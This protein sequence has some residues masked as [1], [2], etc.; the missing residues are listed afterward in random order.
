MKNTVYRLI[1]PRNIEAQDEQITIKDGEVLVRPKYLA[2]CAADQRYYLGKR[3]KAD[4]EKKLPLALI[5][6]SWGEIESSSNSGFSKGDKVFMIPNIPTEQDAEIEENYLRS[7]KFHG[8]S[9]DGFMQQHVVMNSDRVVKF[10]NIDKTVA[11]IAEMISVAIHA[12]STF[13]ESVEQK[14]GTIG[15]WGDGN[16]GFL[17]C[18]MLK[19]L[20]PTFKVTVFGIDQ[21]KL[22]QFTFVDE[23]INANNIPEEYTVDFAFECVG[24]KV[25][26]EVIDQIIETI[27]PE[28]TITLMGVSEKSVLINTRMI[29][30]KGLNII[31]RSRSGRAAFVL[32]AEILDGN[33][34]IQEEIKKIIKKTLTIHNVNDMIN[35]FEYDAV[36]SN[37]TVMK[38]EI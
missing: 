23:V 15:V 28:G 6:E 22:D 30:E 12:I 38:W 34:G 35:A 29:L 33:T 17:T 20:L 37:K 7:S 21:Q 32:V 19:E 10:V 11:A 1:K 5:H 4:L 18:L 16:L 3:N 36:S 9:L 31:G 2:I 24:G 27:N 26:E 8:S 13:K 25:T 14:S